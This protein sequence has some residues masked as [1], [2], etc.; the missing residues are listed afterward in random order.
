MSTTSNPKQVLIIRH[1]EKFGD[2]KR[3]NDGGPNLSVRGSAGAVRSST[4]PVSLS[5]SASAGEFI[6]SYQRIPLKGS[7]PRFATPHFIFATQE[8]KHS[9]RPI[10]TVTPSPLS[11]ALP[12]TR[13]LAIMTLRS[14]R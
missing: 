4:A 8:S 2:P 7:A 13:I 14:T 3:D 5:T 11:L 10:E 9:K 6:G 12:I 1:G